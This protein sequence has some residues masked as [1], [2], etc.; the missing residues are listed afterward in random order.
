MDRF[1]GYY[2]LDDSTM[3][4]APLDWAHEA[5]RCYRKYRAD[6]IVGEVNNGGEMVGLTINTA[7]PTVPFYPV[8]A[9]RGKAIRA[10]PI[11]AL[12][13]QNRVHH[14]GELPF[15]ELETQL[16]EWTPASGEKS[17]DRL[18]ALVWGLSYLHIPEG[19][20]TITSGYRPN[21]SK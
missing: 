18:D 16:C 8:H 15:V 5:V 10:E 6:M 3:K 19:D 4:G 20:Q 13:Q 21:F 7:D 2:V 12:Y 14:V 11:S 17:P 9:S 1:G